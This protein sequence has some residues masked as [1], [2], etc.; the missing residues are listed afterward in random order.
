M[1]KLT[2]DE[3]MEMMRAE[4]TDDLIEKVIHKM[5]LDDRI[6]H[7]DINKSVS[8]STVNSY[9]TIQINIGRSS[10]NT[11]VSSYEVNNKNN[12]T[13]EKNQINEDNEYFQAIA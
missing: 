1:A 4:I 6:A 9:S 10:K 5:G 11:V 13:H 12:I 3:I 8:Y 7:H 2:Y